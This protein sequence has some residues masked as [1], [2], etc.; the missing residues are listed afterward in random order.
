LNLFRF[1]K[2][3][4]V[5]ICLLFVALAS[6]V[7]LA[8]PGIDLWFSDLFYRSRSGFWLRRNGALGFL[9]AT[10]D[11]LIAVAVVAL[12]ASMAVKLARPE[13]P[14]PIRPDTVVFLLSTLVLAPL[15]LVNVVL[16]NSWGRPRP[17]QVDLFGGDAPYVE[18]WR[19]TDWCERNCSFVSGEA[20]S[21]IWLVAVA[22]VLPK[23]VRAPAVVVAGVYALLLSLN[24]IAFGGH[25]LSDVVISFGLTFLVIAVMHRVVIERPPKWLS[26]ETLETGLTRVGRSLR[27]QR[28]GAGTA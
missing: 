23:A 28:S 21:A 25:F 22:M 4:P 5:A 18:V 6:A 13:K 1:L 3:N 17:V 14:S 19:I 15:L 16:K 24:R 26:S 11:A 12:I 7:F 10:N 27:G 2:A 8:F 9:R 20:S